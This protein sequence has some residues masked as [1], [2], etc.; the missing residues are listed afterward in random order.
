MTITNPAPKTFACCTITTD[1]G[2]LTVPCEPIN[3]HLAITPVFGMDAD[4]SSLLGGDFI[5]THR[6]TGMAV[7][8]GPGCLECCRGAGRALVETGVDWGALNRDN[9]GNISQS[10][11][12]ELRQRVAEARTVNWSCDAEYCEPW[13]AKAAAG[14]VR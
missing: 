10:W 1:S 5:I 12:D 2:T 11:S 8:D 13:P 3:D 6:A 9:V 7:S 4:G 14:G